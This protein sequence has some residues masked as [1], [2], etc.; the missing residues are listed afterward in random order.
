MLFDDGIQVAA[1]VI[2]PQ[3]TNW[4]QRRARKYAWWHNLEAAI[5]KSGADTA[6]VDTGLI[7]EKLD[8]T[9]QLARRLSRTVDFRIQL[10]HFLFPSDSPEVLQ[11]KN[12]PAESID[13]ESRTSPSIAAS[14]GRRAGLKAAERQ[15]W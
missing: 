10:K 14:G 11:E 7:Q 5:R 15:R 1:V 4:P 6:A 9:A 3:D 8:N 12:L 13:F 2:D